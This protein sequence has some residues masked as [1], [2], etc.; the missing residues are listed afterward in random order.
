MNSVKTLPPQE[1]EFESFQVTDEHSENHL[2]E[3][4]QS[5]PNTVDDSTDTKPVSS[6]EN[7]APGFFSIFTN[8]LKLFKRS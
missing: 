6:S 3:D 5:E 7:F 1:Q 2:V 8:F 4:E